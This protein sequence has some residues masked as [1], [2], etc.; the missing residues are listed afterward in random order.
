M[1]LGNANAMNETTQS[2]SPSQKSP[3]SK[4]EKRE[5]VKDYVKPVTKMQSQY[6]DLK[7]PENTYLP[8][9]ESRQNSKSPMRQI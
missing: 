5:R 1:S 3:A 7:N 9:I 4:N 8:Q 2:V 6:I